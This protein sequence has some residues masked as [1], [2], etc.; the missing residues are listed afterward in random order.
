MGS[1]FSNTNINDERLEEGI[2]E[3][4][5]KTYIETNTNIHVPDSIINLIFKFHGF[6][7]GTF[8]SNILTSSL[9]KIKLGIMVSKMVNNQS[10]KLDRI[11][12]GIKEDFSSSEF[13]SKCDN[14]GPTI[15]LVLNEYNTIF[16]GY[17]S[18]SWINNDEYYSDSNAFLFQLKP[19]M[20]IFHQ[21]SNN[22]HSICARNTSIC[23]FGDGDDLNISDACNK[24]KNSYTYP[25]SF[26]FNTG[27][28]LVGGNDESSKLIYFNVVDVEVF[29]VQS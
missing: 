10:I 2:I 14:K 27:Y 4:M 15:I 3:S 12:S 29:Q 21:K 23:V 7:G 28:Q 13:H 24:N 25:Y 5:I 1:C 9:D 19:N 16:G 6:F 26:E 17:T 20:N 11:Y 22:N 18:L 8:E